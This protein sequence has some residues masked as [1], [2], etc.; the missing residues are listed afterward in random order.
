[1]K[2]DNK[3][4][5]SLLALLA[6]FF[7]AGSAAA[8]DWIEAAPSGDPMKVAIDALSTAKTSCGAVK[9]AKRLPDGIVDANCSSGARFLVFTMKG[10]T[11]TKRCLPSQALGVHGC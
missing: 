2:T 4:T 8:A 11:M 1:M 9:K 3:T 5:L 6:G 7:W 10:A